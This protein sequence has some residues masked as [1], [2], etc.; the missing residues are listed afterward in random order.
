MERWGDELS[1]PRLK[2][3]IG[4]EDSIRMLI[5]RCMICYP[6]EFDHYAHRLYWSIPRSWWDDE[7][8]EDLE[9]ARQTVE[10]S[11]PVTFCGVPY[12]EKHEF[13]EEVDWRKVFNAILN[14][15]NRR[16]LLIAQDRIEAITDREMEEEQLE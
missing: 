2:G 6:E 11:V 9:D 16:N 13:A 15:C 4:Y 7:F 12:E 14:L 8:I 1:E 3:K 5:N 10:V